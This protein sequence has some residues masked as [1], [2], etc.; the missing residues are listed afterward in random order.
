MSVDGDRPSREVDF[1]A[2]VAEGRRDVEDEGKED[3]AVG[4]DVAPGAVFAYRREAFGELVGF[5]EIEGDKIK[6]Y[7]G[8]YLYQIGSG[9]V[10]QYCGP[11]LYTL[12]S[13]KIQRYC[14]SYLLEFDGKRVKRYCGNY[15]AEVEGNRIKQ[16]CGPYLYEIEGFVSN[17]Q[18]MALIAILFA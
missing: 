4:V 2:A 13:D 17:E 1:G 14:G 16:Y 15:I 7:C 6:E 9:K 3:V 10:Q 5:L 8:R 12:S 18:M 11:Y